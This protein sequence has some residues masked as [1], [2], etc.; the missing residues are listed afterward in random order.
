MR[1][2]WPALGRSATE[3]RNLHI[4]LYT[5]Y[6]LSCPRPQQIYRIPRL[7]PLG[8]LVTVNVPRDITW[9]RLCNTWCPSVDYSCV[10][11]KATTTSEE[12]NYKTCRFHEQKNLVTFIWLCRY[13]LRCQRQL[14]FAPGSF[15]AKTSTSAADR[16]RQ[17]TQITAHPST[18]KVT[19]RK[20]Y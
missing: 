4:I 15:P 10:S 16:I 20:N 5:E 12:C 13:M 9:N 19:L 11:R 2:P 1:R 18:R 3:K 7:Y 14:I 17:K 6:R 8:R